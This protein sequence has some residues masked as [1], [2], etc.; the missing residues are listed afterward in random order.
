MQKALLRLFE[1][2][3]FAVEIAGDGTDGLAMFRASIPSVLVLDLSLP[4]TPGQDICREI[5]QLAPSLPII[6]LSARTEVMDK[7]LLLELGAH[8]YVTKPFSPRGLL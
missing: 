5:S 4:G 1:A 3:G 7:V 8:D 2:E 6:I